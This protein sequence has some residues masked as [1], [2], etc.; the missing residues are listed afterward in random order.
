MSRHTPGPWAAGTAHRCYVEGGMVSFRV[1]GPDG[2]SV[3]AASSNGKRDPHEIAANARLVAMAPELLD[4]LELFVR[5]VADNGLPP[6]QLRAWEA[7]R[8]ALAKVGA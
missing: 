6:T 3:C 7:A 8:A 5:D 2:R 1:T 4:A